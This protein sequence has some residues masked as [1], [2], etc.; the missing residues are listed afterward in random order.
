MALKVCVALVAPA[1]M[2]AR[3][4][5]AVALEWPTETRTPSAVA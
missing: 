3:V 2:A 1:S 5:A 4:S